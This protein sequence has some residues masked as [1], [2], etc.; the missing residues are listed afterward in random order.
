MNKIFAHNETDPEAEYRIVSKSRMEVD[1]K[2]VEKDLA[3]QIGENQSK[4]HQ[5]KQ[6]DLQMGMKMAASAEK[7]LH[8]ANKF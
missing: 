3:D 1:Y 5:E 7:Q 4:K 2:K 6:N 8:D